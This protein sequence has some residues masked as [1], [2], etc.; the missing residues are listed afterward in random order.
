MGR[1]RDDGTQTLS[2]GAE[3][4]AAESVVDE[5]DTPEADRFI[6]VEKITW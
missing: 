1:V 2:E 6:E 3:A 5:L 4:Q